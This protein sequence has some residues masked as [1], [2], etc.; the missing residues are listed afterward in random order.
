MAVDSSGKLVGMSPEVLFST[1]PRSLF[2]DNPS[3]LRDLGGVEIFRNSGSYRNLSVSALSYMKVPLAVYKAQWSQP[4]PEA[5]LVFD[6]AN[7][8]HLRSIEEDF[9]K[10]TH[11]HEMTLPLCLP[12]GSLTAENLSKA[13]G[14]ALKLVNFDGRAAFDILEEAARRGHCPLNLRALVGPHWR[15]LAFI[16][17]QAALHSPYNQQQW[18]GPLAAYPNLLAFTDTSLHTQN[19]FIV[20]QRVEELRRLGRTDLEVVDV[21]EKLNGPGALLAKAELLYKADDGRS[22]SVGPITEMIVEYMLRRERS[23]VR[24]CWEVAM[25]FANDSRLAAAVP[26]DDASGVGRVTR[27]AYLV[28]EAMLRLDPNGSNADAWL[29]HQQQALEQL[30]RG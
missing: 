6:I 8:A 26:E 19:M 16:S 7:K 30:A 9:T 12:D 4:T 27:L 28:V 11:F 22:E 17:L 1:T 23:P 15:L 29:A 5:Q 3:L 13:K 25:Q 18:Q 14:L 2:T 20:G 10:L 24:R 21:L